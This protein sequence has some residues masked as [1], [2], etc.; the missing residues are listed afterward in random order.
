MA[1]P[2]ADELGIPNSDE[3]LASRVPLSTWMHYTDAEIGRAAGVSRERVRQIRNR[4]DLPRPRFKDSRRPEW[5][6]LLALITDSDWRAHTVEA[7]S[8]ELSIPAEYVL[9]WRTTNNKP[10]YLNISPLH[11]ITDEEWRTVPRQKLAE[12]YGVSAK[13]INNFMLRYDKPRL[14]QGRGVWLKNQRPQE[15]D[16][17]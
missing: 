2:T 14:T 3:P 5:Q 16:I 4:L 17:E 8:E 12:E 10:V 1:G 15:A 9:R 7:I 6:R 11:E 13:G